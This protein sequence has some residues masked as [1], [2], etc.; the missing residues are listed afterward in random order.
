MTAVRLAVMCFSVG[1]ELS[2]VVFPF[3]RLPDVAINLYED[4]IDEAELGSP[5]EASDHNETEKAF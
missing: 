5:I 4:F 3:F 1:S 2:D